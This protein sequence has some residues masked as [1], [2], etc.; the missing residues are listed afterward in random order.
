V[1]A[2]SGL[3][4][5][6]L[7]EDEWRSLEVYGRPR[8]FRTRQRLFREGEPGDHVLAI[9]SGR[10]KV[11]VQT[12][13]GREILLAVKEPGDLVGELSVIDGR[14]RSAT[15]IALDPVD[16]LVVPAPAFAEFVESH[17]RIAVRLL[18]TLAA[19]IRD[20]DRRS[21]D[22]DTGDITCRVARRLVDLAERLG[23]HR[24][25]GMEITLALSQDDLAAWVGATREA[26]SRALGGLRAD[27]CLTT[28]RQ[29]IVLTDLPALRRKAL[30]LA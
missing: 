6:F 4:G 10:V 20:A 16:A 22:R 25:S 1:V 5:R 11:S 21:V 9:R 28:G 7:S 17:P 27:G 29:R 15:A 8:R 23:E 12:R 2:G 14:P 24:G 19:Q 3:A 30:E 18:R 13:S 26:T